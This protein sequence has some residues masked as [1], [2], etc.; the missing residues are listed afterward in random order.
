[1]TPDLVLE[2]LATIV[3][4]V[5]SFA[6]LPQIYRIFKRRSAK[7]ISIW[8]YAYMLIAGVIWVLYGF[9][10]QNFPIMITNLIGTVAMIGIIV[11]WVLY[12]RE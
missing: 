8:T 7:D 1:M 10:I 11:G 5:S 3:G 2:T 4:V 12:G 9:N 6:M